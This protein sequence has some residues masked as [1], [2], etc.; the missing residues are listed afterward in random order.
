MAP[1]VMSQTDLESNS[2][3]P[4]THH[5]N[6]ESYDLIRIQLMGALE[7]RAG[8]LSRVVMNDLERRLLQ[9]Q[10]SNLF[11]TFLVAVV[12]LACVERMCWLFKTWEDSTNDKSPQ[13]M[14]I[15]SDGDIAQ[16]LQASQE[17]MQREQPRSTRW[18][19]DK[20][21]AYYS[22]QGE[23]FSDILY[24]LLKMRGVPPKPVSR[25]EDGQLILRVDEA[26]TMAKEW[27]DCI[28]VT[29]ETLL[30]RGNARF[31]GSSPAKW[32][33]KYVRKIIGG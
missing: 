22:Q 24:M 19:L 31:E 15:T 14:T 26:D 30:E 3:T 16:A 23:R 1:A 2:R 27:Y 9:R 25:P 33:L 10:Q 6:R 18:P 21:P 11:E 29:A 4:I 7:K 32:E 13:L 12:L 17:S 5:N 8:T 20:M 28:G